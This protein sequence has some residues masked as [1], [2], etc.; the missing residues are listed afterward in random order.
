MNTDAVDRIY[1]G[2]DISKD[3]LDVDWPG[4]PPASHVYG[5]AALAKLIRQ[6]QGSVR[7]VHVV[8]EPSGGYERA[9][10][11]GLWAAD[12][13]VSLV[14]AS[15]VRA[16]AKAQ[17]LLAKTDELD[18]R[19]L[20][21]F[22]EKMTPS[23]LQPPEPVRERLADLVQRREQLVALLGTEEQRLTQSRDKVVRKLTGK[24]IRE[25]ERQ[26][27][28]LEKAIADVIDDDDT[29]RQQCERMQEVKGIGQVTASTLL[30]TLPELGKLNRKEISALAGVA[31]YNHDSGK[32]RGRRLIRGGRLAVRRV[33]Y[34]AATVAARF[35][36]VL[37]DFYQR[38]LAAGKPKKVALTAVMRKL[39]TL[40]NHLLK[41][42]HFNLA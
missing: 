25:L 3:R 1:V 42:P 13:A 4:Q 23:R 2:I 38:L 22:G 14:N 31:P 28:V 26:I 15:R 37:R 16:F 11:A 29:L 24:L 6:L 17:G 36:P 12:V 34:M 40:L 30:A 18:A 35:N 10:L 8:C 39:V 7:P 21:L 20:R 5:G 41:N 32:H 9:L 27:C 33:L 19:V